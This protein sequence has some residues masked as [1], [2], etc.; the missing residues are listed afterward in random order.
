MRRVAFAFV[1]FL[2]SCCHVNSS[3]TPDLPISIQSKRGLQ[4]VAYLS[5]KPGNASLRIGMI[6]SQGNG[7]TAFGDLVEDARKKAAE[8]GGDFILEE[9]SGVDVSTVHSPGYTTVHRPWSRFSVWVYYPSQLGIRFDEDRL[10]T[11]FHLNSNA[12]KRGIQEGDRILG[13]DG[14]DVLEPN[15]VR[16]LLSIQPNDE[17]RV[18]LQRGTER[19]DCWITALPN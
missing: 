18:T 1:V 13:I 3:F 6:A 15:F 17:V 10:I 14:A 8:L 5:K 12:E 16:R 2:S 4:E 19:L 11:G 9:K 7:G